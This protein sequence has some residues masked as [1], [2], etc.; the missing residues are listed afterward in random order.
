LRVPKPTSSQN[1][2]GVLKISGRFLT[3]LFLLAAFIFG[4]FSA[5][6]KNSAMAA[7]AIGGLDGCCVVGSNQEEYVCELILL[8][9]CNKLHAILLS[10][11]LI[12]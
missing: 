5:A 12:F 1:L 7:A 3:Y 11:H 10:V 9:I 8:Y 4:G 2:A 6:E